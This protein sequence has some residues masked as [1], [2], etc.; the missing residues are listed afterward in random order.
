M[1]L[2][3]SPP[4]SEGAEKARE[5]GWDGWPAAD[6]HRERPQKSGQAPGHRS[7]DAAAKRGP[8]RGVWEERQSAQLCG[9]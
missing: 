6:T 5:F 7:G 9:L 4:H 1:Y 2:G 3:D 8:V